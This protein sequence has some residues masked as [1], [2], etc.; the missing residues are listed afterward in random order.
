MARIMR[1][2]ID[3]HAPTDNNPAMCVELHEKVRTATE[4]R[5]LH[6]GYPKP[7]SSDDIDYLCDILEETLRSL[8]I[9]QLGVADPLVF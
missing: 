5:I 7:L 2:W 9:R 1:L 4:R 6:F 8:I 3:F